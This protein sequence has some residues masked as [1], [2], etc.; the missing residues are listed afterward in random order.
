MAGTTLLGLVRKFG[1]EA[2]FPNTVIGTIE[3]DS[4]Q[5]VVQQWVHWLRESWREEQINKNWLWL[6]REF[7][8]DMVAGQQKYH[9]SD[10]TDMEDDDAIA[11]F[12]HWVQLKKNPVMIYRRAEEA[13]EEDQRVGEMVWY[14]WDLFKYT[15]SGGVDHAEGSQPSIWTIDPQRRFVVSPTP[16]ESDTYYLRGEYQR[17]AQVLLNDDDEP[18]IDEDF[19]MLIVYLAVTTYAT[20]AASTESISRAKSGIRRIR[21]ALGDTEL[22]Q[23]RLGGPIA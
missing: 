19:R 3:G 12:R 8:L 6:R 22:P 10:A 18:E 1:F 7:Q 17:S 11:R 16:T 14:G 9:Y 4:V 2:D 5:P 21:H 13:G 23:M 15:Y 20:T